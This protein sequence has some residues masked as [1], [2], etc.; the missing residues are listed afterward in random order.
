MVDGHLEVCQDLPCNAAELYFR[1]TDFC[2]FSSISWTTV[3]KKS[4]VNKQSL[5]SIINNNYAPIP[6]LVSLGWGKKKGGV[7]LNRYGRIQQFR[8][9]VRLPT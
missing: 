6:Y 3:Q 7:P 4:D 8:S 1:S 2:R 5:R 9:E